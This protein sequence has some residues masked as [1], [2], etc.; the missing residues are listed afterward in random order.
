MP[1]TLLRSRRDNPDLAITMT[2]AT[3][4][5]VLEEW[6]LAG[7]ID[8]ALLDAPRH[9]E[10]RIQTSALLRQGLC[11]VGKAGGRRP[12]VAE[13]GFPT[14][15][16]LPLILPSAPHPVRNAMEAAAQACGVRLHVAWTVDSE[17]VT[18]ELLLRG[19]GCA[20]LPRHSV[21]PEAAAGLLWVR[22]LATPRI[23]RQWMIATARERPPNR[24]GQ[25]VM[26]ALLAEAQLFD[27]PTVWPQAA[28]EHRVTAPFPTFGHASQRRL[29]AAQPAI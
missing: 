10:S 8:M 29:A 24:A 1:G 4:G 15:A 14:I 18:K 23:E 27:R 3:D 13:G 6:L 19:A 12:E 22:E 20:I 26:T 7:R 28:G 2:E 17:L 9:A 25:A 16:T 5:A 11:L 21:A